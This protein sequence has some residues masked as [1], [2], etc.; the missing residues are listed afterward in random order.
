MRYVIFVFSILT[1]VAIIN[2]ITQR[3]Q[4]DRAYVD[5]EQEVGIAGRLSSL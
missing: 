1:V 5:M 4:G 2:L 3:I